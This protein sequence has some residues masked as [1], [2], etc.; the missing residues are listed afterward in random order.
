[1]GTHT[2]TPPD[3]RLALDAIRRIVHALRESSRRA[4]RHVG[5]T[6]A[7]LFVLQKLA[8]AAP[9]SVN[10]LAARTHTHQSTVSTVV[11][12]L[13]ARRLV[14]RTRSVEDGRRVQLS[15]TTA[16]RRLVTRAP[17]VAQ[18]R[19]VRAIEKLPAR[20]RQSLAVT[21][22]ALADALDLV[23]AAPAMF[24]EDAGRRG[25]RVAGRA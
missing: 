2:F 23:G 17:D 13:V 11:A 22:A 10:D 24:F 20:R 3:T 15:L 12:R 18:D 1:M 5:L 6:G 21:L 19:L 7:Q 9:A 14:A 25:G 4:E 8:E 16:G